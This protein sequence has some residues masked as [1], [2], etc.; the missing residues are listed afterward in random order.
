[1]ICRLYD[2]FFSCFH[3]ED[4]VS[5]ISFCCHFPIMAFFGVCFLACLLFT[6][7]EVIYMKVRI[8]E[9]RGFSRP[10][11][12][13]LTTATYK[14]TI[15]DN[16][17]VFC[18]ESSFFVHGLIVLSNF[19]VLSIF[20]MVMYK[21]LSILFKFAQICGVYCLFLGF[22]RDWLTM[23]QLS[24]QDYWLTMFRLSGQDFSYWQCYSQV[25]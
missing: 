1:M 18:L 17:H 6:Y 4:S 5:S 21:V 7:Y 20:M 15:I 11:F 23:F 22:S 2:H 24:G 12:R 9:A 16:W 8:L 14:W 10:I 25:S 13:F 3:V 19:P